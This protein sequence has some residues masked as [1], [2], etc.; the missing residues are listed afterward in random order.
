MSVSPSSTV[1]PS[2]VLQRQPRAEGLAWRQLAGVFRIELRRNLLGRRSLALYFLAAMPLLVAVAWAIL[3][4][5]GHGPEGVAAEADEIFAVLFHGFLRAPL[6]LGVLL[7]FMSLFRSEILERSLHYYLLTPVRRSLLLGGKYLA[8]L[9]VTAG[10]F[11]TTTLA[12]FVLFRAHLGWGEALAVLTS[13]RGLS[14]LATYLG[15]TL[16]A[17]LGYGAIF[18]LVGLF[19]RN[20]VIAAFLVWTWETIHPVLPALLKRLGILH[21][22]R[23]LYPIPINEQIQD[24]PFAVLAEP[25]SGWL[26]VPGI[27]A[28][29]ALVLAIALWRLRRIEISYGED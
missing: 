4:Q 3:G 10:V 2:P 22:L 13:G 24:I 18:L 25:T 6:F 29:T 14:Q 12:L 8:A 11:L 1:A 9:T 20:P 26:S 21:Y 15:I 19:F 16:L 7:V 5:T 23:S 27:L 28:V 17:C